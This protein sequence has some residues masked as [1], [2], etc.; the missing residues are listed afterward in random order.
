MCVEKKPTL[1]TVS[2][3]MT[4]ENLRAIHVAMAISV[5]Y[6]LETKF[7]LLT[8]LILGGKCKTKIT[9]WHRQY[10]ENLE[11]KL[12][13]QPKFTDKY[14]IRNSN[15]E[16]LYLPY[17]PNIRRR[18]ILF[19]PDMILVNKKTKNFDFIIEVEYQIN[20]KKIVGISI[21]T[22]IAVRQMNPIYSSTLILITK[23]DFPN[24]KLIEKEIQ[25]YVKNIKFHL[26]NSND[27]GWMADI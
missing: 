21:L 2:Y 20:Y 22:D 1:K 9:N 16:R 12:Q 8:F 19:N 6:V 11:K 18:D 17:K 26:T 15:N 23:K 27:F 4:V 24:S 13:S 5:I 3:A 25:R 10:L 7:S 14:R